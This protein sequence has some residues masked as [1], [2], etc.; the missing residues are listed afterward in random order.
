MQNSHK[1]VGFFYSPSSS[2]IFSIPPT[3]RLV[4]SKPS[5]TSTDTEPEMVPTNRVFWR[6][7]LV[8][9]H[10]QSGLLSSQYAAK[11]QESIKVAS[12]VK[13]HNHLGSSKT[14]SIRSVKNKN[15]TSSRYTIGRDQYL[16]KP[17]HKSNYTSCRS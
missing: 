10:I 4:V 1:N 9:Q 14:A 15:P 13:N 11:E 2:A 5:R 7:P 12:L 6:Y 16:K 8:V 17:K 3:A